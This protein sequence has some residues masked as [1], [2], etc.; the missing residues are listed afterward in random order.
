MPTDIDLAVHAVQT[1]G[2][3]IGKALG[4]GVRADWKGPVDPVTEVDRA[5]EEQI[6]ELLRSQRPEDGI[7][8]EEGG[9]VRE[10]TRQWII[11]PIDGTVNFIHGIPQV[12]CS[13]GLWV[14]GAPSVG[15]V[16]DVG[17]G[18]VFAAA[19]G[20][21]ATLNGRRIAVS[22]TLDLSEAVI[23]TG[24]PY[25]R[26]QRSAELAANVERMLRRSRAIRRMGSAALDIAWVACGRYDG[27]WEADVKVWD[28]AAAALVLTEAGGTITRFDAGPVDEAPGSV[29]A[30]NGHIHSQIIDALGP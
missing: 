10:A 25:D 3:L 4:T 9:L 23:G 24:F 21:G 1:A 15:A 30:S 6:V 20:E 2:A 27:Y 16:L 12:A 11:D 19:R 28:L 29:I 13:V 17:R 14:G 22:A 5:A 26:L 18:E 7:L 8:G